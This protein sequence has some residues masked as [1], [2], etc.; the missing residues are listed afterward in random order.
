M[1]TA[2]L[3]AALRGSL[4]Y[5]AISARDLGRLAKNPGCQRLATLTL[6]NSSPAAAIKHVFKQD[7]KEEQSVFAIRR[8]QPSNAHKLNT[9]QPAS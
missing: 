2:D 7:A 6:I 4:P 3:A 9:V 8:G 1:S 5:A